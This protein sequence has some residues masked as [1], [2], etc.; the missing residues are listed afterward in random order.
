MSPAQ[1]RA[2]GDFLVADM[3]NEIPT[4]VR[5]IEAVPGDRLDYQPDAKS[6]T[7]IG[8]VRHLIGIDA[9][10]LDSI[11]EGAFTKG[12]DPCEVSTPSEGA[13]AYK[14]A[15]SAALDRVQAMSDDKLAEEIDFFGYMKVPAVNLLSMMIK[16]SVHHRGQLSSYLRAMGGKVPDIYGQSGDSKPAM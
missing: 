7:G 15:V 10:F 9:W 8:L 1:G 14:R 16:H 6:S 11:A 5:V 13:A 12:P 3:K 2:I 4:T